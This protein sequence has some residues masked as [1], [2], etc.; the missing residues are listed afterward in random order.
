MN[1][2][3]NN[4]ESAL[5]AVV[6]YKLRTIFCL[7]SVSLG[8]ASITVI[9]ASVEG[10]YKKAYDFVE[11]FGPETV[12]IFGGSEEQ[13]ASGE[14]MKAL[15][16]NDI[17]AIGDTFPTA[18]MVVPIT[19]KGS[20]GVSYK[21][22]KHQTLV[23]GSTEDYSRSWA[24]PIEEGSDLSSEDTAFGRGVCLIGRQVAETLFK[25]TSPIGKTLLIN[26]KIPCKVTGVLADRS[27]SQAGIDLNNRIIMPIG[28]VMKK[29]LKDSKYIGAIKIK[30]QDGHNLKHWMAQLKLFLRDRH[31]LKEGQSDDFTIVSPEEIIKFLVA[32]TGSL[33]VFLGISGVVSLVVSGFVL[34]NLFL[35]SIKE[36]TQEI[37]IRRA[38]GAK[39][40]D[41]FNQ[42][43]MEASL[44]TSAGGVLGFVIGYGS[45][46]LLVLLAEFPMHFSWKAFAIGFTL[47]VLTGLIFGVQ[48]A[49]SAA[50]LSPIE[51]IK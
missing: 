19:M 49:R 27:A 39:K 30:F 15:T 38:V 46:K 18:T 28:V 31:Q 43:I 3:I 42:F 25:D 34:A 10:A 22:V 2:L 4:I 13:R 45:S 11:K 51:A 8:I 44:I 47:S 35:L 16:L 12:L 33:V 20:T 5:H 23:I 37:G 6:S 7:F 21:D 17:K 40:R 50:N 24:W 9:V 26:M 48:P 41:I 1:R 14:K 29:L 32:L 36:R